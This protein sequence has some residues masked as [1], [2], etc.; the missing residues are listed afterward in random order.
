M[1][2]HAIARKPG[3]NFFNGLTTA[4]LGVPDY[5]RMIRQH[6]AYI[7]AL[8]SVGLE[9]IVL[10][11][12]IKYPDGYFVEDVA[13]LTPEIAVITNPGAMARKGE[14]DSIEL[15]LRRYRP[16]VRIQAPGTVEGGDVL[17]IGM[18]FF[19]GISARTN[20]EG[21]TQL[22]QILERYGYGWTSVQVEAGLHLKS[23]VNS[24]G[25]DTLLVV[26]D[27]AERK[28]F[29]GYAKIIVPKNE[30]YAANTLWINNH[31]FMP[32][33]FPE[34]RGR[35]AAAGLPLVELD[36][37]EAQKMDGGLTCMSLRF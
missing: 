24:V 31:L 7:Q 14:E 5:T 32:S 10:E 12:D 9:V 8:R 23:N 6:E 4:H 35:L 33:G 20:R 2:T 18:H 15:L 36:M 28:E 11:A 19:I 26:E 27:Y 13:I 30:A 25:E 17:M 34:T 16:T 21:A 29:T 3:M 37:S 22:A 1:F